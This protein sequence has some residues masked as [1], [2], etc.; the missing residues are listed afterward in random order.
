MIALQSDTNS[1]AMRVI[2]E[3]GFQDLTQ[4]VS[5]CTSKDFVKD[6]EQFRFAGWNDFN[7]VRGLWENVRLEKVC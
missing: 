1:D 5:L 7:P 6:G 4:D 3:N 2:K